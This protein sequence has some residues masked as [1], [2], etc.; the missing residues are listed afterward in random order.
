MFLLVTSTILFNLLCRWFVWFKTKAYYA[1]SSVVSEQCFA[2]ITPY[3]HHG[4]DMLVLPPM[5]TYSITLIQIYKPSCV[6]CTY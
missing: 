3:A 1:P 6:R 4:K 5:P 2:H